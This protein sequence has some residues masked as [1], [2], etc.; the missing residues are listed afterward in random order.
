M[1]ELLQNKNLGKIVFCNM[2]NFYISIGKDSVLLNNLLGLK[3]SCF[4]PEI[5]KVGFPINS[6]EKYT[7]LIQEKGYSY[8][9]YYFDQQKEELKILKEYKGK[10]INEIKLENINC[11][12]CSKNTE[13]YKKPDKY[14][15]ALSKL[16][17][18]EQEQN[19]ESNNNLENKKQTVCKKNE[20]INKKEERKRKR[21]IWFQNKNK[22]IN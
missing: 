19:I 12:I 5:C 18:K 15:L 21:K 3:V 7:D 22:K 11:Y 10:Y 17:E 20:Y 2:G 16:Y 1:M 4:K 6:L 8:I 13:K 9:V 14:I